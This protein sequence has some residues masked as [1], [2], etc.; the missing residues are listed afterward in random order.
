MAE[1]LVE[2]NEPLTDSDGCRYV[3]RACGAEGDN[4]HWQG[5][6]EFVPVEGGE[7]LR[8]GRET[9]QPNRIDTLYWATGLTAV[10]LEGA[11]DRARRPLVRR[12]P[13]EVSPPAHDEPAPDFAAEPPE[14]ILNPF[15]V[16]RKGES[17]LRRQLAAFSVWHLVNIVVA[18]RLSD[19]A[20]AALNRM[21]SAELAELIVSAVRSRTEH[22]PV[23]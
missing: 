7:T 14:S 4:G 1:V 23:K 21:T 2:F 19:D 11:L 17:L 18:H 8:S 12:P 3:A 10:Y 20:P 15:S 5:W 6:I 13:R 16:Y 22:V 9:T